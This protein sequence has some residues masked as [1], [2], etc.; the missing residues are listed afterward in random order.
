MQTIQISKLRPHVL[1]GVSILAL[2]LGAPSLALAQAAPAT[3]AAAAAAAGGSTEVSEVVVT[4]S[5]IVRDGYTAPTPT[6]VVGAADIAKSSVSNVADYVNQLPQ[7]GSAV[8]NSPRTTSFSSGNVGGTNAL[9]LRNLGNQ[10]TLTLL[11]GHR[12]VGTNL[13][14]VV[15]IDLLPMNLISRVDVVTGGASAAWGSDAVAGVVNFVLDKEFV[16]V[17]GEISYGQTFLNDGADEAADI[18]IGSKFGNDRGH[19]LFSARAQN[20]SGIFSNSSRDWYVGYKAVANQAHTATN[21]TPGFVALDHAGLRLA[22]TGGVIT[23]GPLAGVQFGPGGTVLPYTLATQGGGIIGAGGSVEDIGGEYPILAGIKNEQIFG[24]VSYDVTDHINVF[25]EL[26]MGWDYGLNYTSHFIRHGDLSIKADNPFI[27]AALQ[28]QIAAAGVTQFNIGRVQDDPGM[29]PLRIKN[30]RW[31]QRYVAGASGDLDWFNNTFKWNGYY[32]HGETDFYTENGHNAILSNFAR[33]VDAVRNPAVGGIA[34][35][36]VG[37]PVCRSTLADPTN[38]CVAFNVFG[39]GS[40]S[41]ASIAYVTGHSYQRVYI[42][43]DVASAGFQLEPFSVPAGPVS[44]AGGL[45]W[46]K[47]QYHNN[48]DSLD[49]AAPATV[50]PYWFGNYKV[51][52]GQYTVKEGFAEI[53]VPI[54]K[55]LPFFKTLDFNGAVRETDYSTSGKVTT[56]KAGGTWDVNDDLR[57]RATRSRDIRAPNLN[58]LYLAGSGAGVGIL[59]PGT[60][61]QAFINTISGGVPTLVP[62]IADTTAYGV[63]YRPSWF[64]GFSASL[65]RYQINVAKAIIT[66]TPQ[67]IVNLCY[68]VGSPVT[69]SACAEIILNSNPQS[70]GLVGQLTQAIILVGG[71]NIAEQDVEG[72]DIEASYRT[73]LSELSSSM[74]GAI[75]IRAVGTYLTKYTQTIGSTTTNFRDMVFAGTQPIAGGP[76]WKW[77]IT[78]TYSLGPSNTT[79]TARYVGKAV[80]NN[81]APGSALSVDKNNIPRKVYFGL[82]ETWNID[83]FGAKGQVYAK[84]DNLLDTAPAKVASEAGTAYAASGSEGGYYDLVGRAW[85]VGLRFRY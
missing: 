20:A 56:W 43:Q 14:G 82:G 81:A 54:V 74:P 9:N 5:R 26:G 52:H 44:L 75:D 30:T 78:G 79:L 8:G 83:M 68:G 57:F 16:G 58:D 13:T 70:P 80:V 18:A 1:S 50:A 64:H 59:V 55:D 73:E 24:R 10:R 28:P 29:G 67:Q 49:A 7:V 84:I 62:E 31:Q 33:A 32:Q 47:E 25:G 40:P 6:T 17:K 15:D 85:R 21:G 61:S 69:P 66:Q 37:A 35:V 48:V 4:A 60:N 38:G 42:E 36:A 41:A 46:R 39:K 71:A 45:E 23:A 27:P 72:W 2:S 19:V 11:D 3:T 63:V 51:G 22:T 65:D 53:I 34:G 12:V 77:L 76:N